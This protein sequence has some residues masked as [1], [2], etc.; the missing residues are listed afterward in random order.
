MADEQFAEEGWAIK[1][2]VRVIAPALEPGGMPRR[3]SAK[4]SPLDC[5]YSLWTDNIIV[6]LVDKIN[7][8]MDKARERGKYGK[9]VSSFL[10]CVYL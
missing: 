6:H 9:K 4:C 2:K 5:F 1:K 10:V 8:K 3:L 7:G